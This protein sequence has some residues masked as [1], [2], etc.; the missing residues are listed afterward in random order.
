MYEPDF[1]RFEDIDQPSDLPEEPPRYPYIP[2]DAAD[3]G[4]PANQMPEWQAR[5]LNAVEQRPWLVPVALVIV[6]VL[7]LSLV[8]IS[9]MAGGKPAVPPLVP[10]AQLSPEEGGPGDRFQVT[11]TGWQPGDSVLVRL[12]GVV[13]GQEIQAP[14]AYV[15]VAEDG[16][17]SA[18]FIF[19]A[20]TKLADLP[21]VVVSAQSM[22]TGDELSMVLRVSTAPV[23]PTPTLTPIATYPTPETTPTPSPTLTPAVPTA[24][25][26]PTNT[27]TPLEGWQGEY[28]NDRGLASGPILVRTDAVINFDWGTGSPVAGLHADNFSVRWTRTPY[29]H[30]G[31]HR[32]SVRSDDGVRVWLDGELI[33]NQWHDAGSATYTA[34]RKLMAGPHTLRVEYYEGAGAAS[35][36]F[37]WERLGEFP[38]WRGEYYGNADLA[39]QPVLLRND[40]TIAFDWGRGAPDAVLPIDEFSARWTRVLPFEEGLYRFHIWVDDGVRLYVDDKLVADEWQDGARREVT[41]D[42][43]MSAGNHSLRVEYYERS[44]DA[45]IHIWW[46]KPAAYPDWRAEYWPNT[47]LD[48]S[49]ALVRNDPAV[50]FNWAWSGP[51]EGIPADN[52]SVRWTRATQF[53]RATYRFH[54][55]V[56]DGARLWVD[57]NLVIDEWIDGAAR[58]KTADYALTQGKHDLRV[59]Y[60]ENVGS[61]QI[62]V[63]WEQVSSPAYPDWKAEYWSNQNLTGEPDLVRNDRAVE[64]NWGAGSPAPGLP[65]DFFSARWSR[66]VSFDPGFYRIYARADDG[67]RVFIDDSLVLDEWHISNGDQTY[68]AERTLSGQHR[69]EVTYYERTGNGMVQLWWERVGDRPTDTPTPTPQPTDTL[70][71]TPTAS[72]TTGPT[73]TS[74]ATPEPTATSTATPEP[75]ATSTPTQE[76]TPGPTATPTPTPTGTL[77]PQDTATPTPTPTP[78]ATTAPQE[79]ATA[80]QTQEP[81]PPTPEPTLTPT[82]PPTPTATSETMPTP[83]AVGVRINEV[84]PVTGTTNLTDTA[85][86]SDEW[87]ELYNG[88]GLAVDL[89]N[90]FLLD[91]VGD[92]VPYQIPEG[93]VLAPGEFALFLGQQTGLTLDDAGD[94]VQLIGPDGVM[95]DKVTF[96]PLPPNASYS[97][98]DEGVW[99]A[100]W[101]PSPGAPNTPVRSEMPEIA[102]M[103]LA[104]PPHPALAEKLAEK[105]ESFR[106]ERRASKGR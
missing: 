70:T 37:W 90:W 67:I 42:H 56:D 105:R 76:P 89:H 88:G 48:G 58:E 33:I 34:D 72:P 96:G 1:D 91:T 81:P 10:T 103:V 84:M 4:T 92:S 106:R 99:H 15:V 77:Q 62:R 14:L 13:D 97:L 83:V 100:D 28:Y 5:L 39:G 47:G 38:Q 8:G 86:I 7:G 53:D 60:Y 31:T 41:V 79:T 101:P 68:V 23:S 9:A 16:T 40:S 43:Q 27:P 95:A 82:P 2:P 35:I 36:R 21:R 45:L 26:Q 57:G 64:F 85:I 73:P 6:G 51:G 46:E 3:T 24:V 54:V 52:F 78:T 32:F 94:E 59:E 55:L 63:W 44:G 65:V 74:T 11:G 80:T 12:V 75:T 20:D 30:A 93:P 104:T 17:F 18:P 71:P 61:A 29:F 22:D 69:L 25:P 66:Q 98:D 102:E 19:P 50:D 87:I 49:P